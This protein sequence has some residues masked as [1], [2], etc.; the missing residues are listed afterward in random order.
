MA[1]SM[2]RLL[3]C[4]VLVLGL[5]SPRLVA[6][7]STWKV[8]KVSL[9]PESNLAGRLTVGLS[10]GG[11]T[12]E[13]TSEVRLTAVSDEFVFR[14]RLVVIGKVG[15]RGQASGVVIFDL[16]SR[17][18]LDWFVCWEAMR[19]S[20][21]WIASVEWYPEHGMRWPTDVVLIYDLDK[22]P[23]QNRLA[24][25]QPRFTPQL[26]G[27]SSVAVGFPVYP[28]ANAVG[29]T[30][31]NV[32]PDAESAVR[33]LGAPFFLLLPSRWLVFVAAQGTDYA[34]SENHLVV[35]DLSHGLL[36]PPAR[37]VEIPREG[38]KK[39][40]KNPDMTQI[41]GME[42]VGEGSVRLLLPES[43]YGVNN[44]VVDLAAG[45]LQ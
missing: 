42:P 30:Y 41:E 31:T 7:E 13:I 27:D 40:G 38:F 23:G 9:T 8:D 19:I 29:G 12:F 6:S 24:N 2:T 32:V 34:S 21:S 18:L 36:K 4:T 37:N 25:A 39:T 10:R 17:K 5:L 35:V 15:E 1:E 43:E 33:V 45:K 14:D 28:A 26:I 11:S 3:R 20:E 44:E 16:A 22:S